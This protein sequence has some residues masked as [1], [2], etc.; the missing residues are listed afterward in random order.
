MVTRLAVVAALLTSLF[1]FRTASAQNTCDDPFPGGQPSFSTRFWTKTDFC[2]RSVEFSDVF[3]GGPPPDGIPPLDDPRFESITHAREWLQDRSPVIALDIDGEAR[4]YPLAIL[5]WH[6]IANDT[7]AGVPVAVT[8]C[9]LCNAGLVFDRRVDGD[10][11]RLGVSGLLRNSDMIMWDDRTQSWWQQ[12]TGEAIVGELTGTQLNILPSSMTSFEAFAERFPEGEVLSRETGFSRQYGM[13][14]YTGYDSSD[15]FLFFGRSDPRLP[16]ME[17]VLGAR[18]G[19]DA[20][21]YPF[22]ELSRV[23]VVNDRLADIPVVAF[24]QPGVASALDTSTID[25]GRDVGFAALYD[26]V[27]DG[28]ELTFEP[29]DAGLVRDTQTGSI[30]DSFGL[31]LSGEYKDRQLQQLLAAPHFWFAWSAFLP[32][33]AVFA[34]S[35]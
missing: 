7:L 34:S 20:K 6:E 5:T 10:A 3:S 19:S 25:D 11:I 2:R 13:N 18:I 27:L 30:W 16:A 32:E 21:A 4:A 31:A 29:D 17:R 35:E 8:F 24:W 28:V 23:G 9:P 12:F 1:A 33:T 22:S 15:P 14:P 26:R